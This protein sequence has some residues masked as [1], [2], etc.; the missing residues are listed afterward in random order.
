MSPE[1]KELLRRSIALSEENNDILR[2]IQRSMRLA[3][4]MTLVYWIFIIGTA[5]GA[6]YVFKPYLQQAEGLY[7]TAKT[8]LNSVSNTFSGYKK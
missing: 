5:I 2:S 6:F 1:E 3:R 8:Q 4:L 7:D